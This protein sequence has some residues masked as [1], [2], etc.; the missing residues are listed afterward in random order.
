VSSSE[1]SEQSSEDTILNPNE[2]RIEDEDEEEEE[3]E[4]STVTPAKEPQ[5]F[6]N[7]KFI[8]YDQSYVTSF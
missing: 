3:E 4:S 5:V 8:I 1:Q 7:E 6:F 2:L